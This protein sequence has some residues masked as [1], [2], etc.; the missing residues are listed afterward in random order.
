MLINYWPF[1]EDTKEHIGNGSTPGGGIS[2][3][4]KK[5]AMGIGLELNSGS[6]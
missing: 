6:V 4:N 2:V 5:N 3:I 1:E